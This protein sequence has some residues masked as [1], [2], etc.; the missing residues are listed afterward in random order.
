M[1]NNND[2][3]DTEPI[4]KSPRTVTK[5][6]GRRKNQKFKPFLVLLYLSEHSDEDHCVNA[7]MIKSYL[8]QLGIDSERRSIYRDIKE[9]NLVLLSLAYGDNLEKAEAILEELKAGYEDEIP[10]VYDYDKKGYY[11]RSE[12]SFKIGERIANRNHWWS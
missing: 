2:L 8:E 11:L 12:Y 4:I 3:I 5:R 6:K 9:L 10:I 1:M 7:R